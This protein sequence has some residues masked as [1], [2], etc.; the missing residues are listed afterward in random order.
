[1]SEDQ[2]AMLWAMWL[3]FVILWMVCSIY[4]TV[5]NVWYH[6]VLVSSCYLRFG[7]RKPKQTSVFSRKNFQ[8]HYQSLSLSLSIYIYIY[9]FGKQ[10]ILFSPRLRPPPNHHKM[11]TRFPEAEP[12][13]KLFQAQMELR[14]LRRVT[15]GVDARIGLA[16]QLISN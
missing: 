11:T 5:W 4:V 1:M 15:H 14:K 13:S 9:V 3:A 2:G 8:V 10:H 6:E 12:P 7:N 16:G